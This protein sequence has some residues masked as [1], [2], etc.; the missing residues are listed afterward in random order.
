VKCRN[1][2]LV[3]FCLLTCGAPAFDGGKW[4][5]GQWT[6]PGSGGIT[7]I[8]IRKVA[9]GFR[10][11][12]LGQCTP[13]DC[14]WGE[15]GVQTYAPAVDAKYRETVEALSAEYQQSFARTLLIMRPAEG[16]RLRV[17]VFTVFTDSS[18]RLPYYRSQTL[19]QSRTGPR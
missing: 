12:V 9:G 18:G 10:L 6:D 13:Q 7:S 5:E 19:T 8:E 3:V 14:D 16:N 1:A 4:F 2:I 17:D 11:H 15:V